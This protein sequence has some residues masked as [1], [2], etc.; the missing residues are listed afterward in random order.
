MKHA[1]KSK[2]Q[3]VAFSERLYKAP[4]HNSPWTF[5]FSDF[6]F[7]PFDTD[8]E[9]YHPMSKVKATEDPVKRILLQS[10]Y[11]L[12]AKGRAMKNQ[13]FS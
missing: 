6:Q 5:G 2:W 4:G 7:Q 9:I 1:I 11:F 13:S 10:E 8:P 12:V 3:T